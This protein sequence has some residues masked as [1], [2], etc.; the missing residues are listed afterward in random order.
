MVRKPIKK[1]Q[2]VVSIGGGLGNQLFQFTAGLVAAGQDQL[3]LELGLGLPNRDRSMS[4]EILQYT[5]PSTVTILDR[6]PR[7]RFTM[8]SINFAMIWGKS[9]RRNPKHPFSILI[10]FASSVV[11]SVYFKSIRVLRAAEGVGYHKTDFKGRYTFL[12]G[13]F[14]TYFWASQE[15][16]YSK[17]KNLRLRAED[18]AIG[19]YKRLA[20]NEKPLIVH[21]RL[22]DYKGIESFG[23]PSQKYYEKAISELW[24]SGD[25]GKI[26]IFT[27]EQAEAVHYLPEWVIKNC[28]WIPEIGGSAAQTLEVMRHGVGYVIANSTYSWWGAFL[29]YTAN[30]KVIAPTPWFKG[31]PSPLDIIPPSWETVEAWRL[32][33]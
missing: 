2:T 21:V 19:E 11:I 20:V 13:Y 27:N 26:W 28:R 5:L 10:N 12:V 32:S 23:I 31:E 30:P 7:T 1:N 29:S 9:A 4:P 14:Q 3:V 16:T 24:G 6:Q 18:L 22:G 8:R 17:L 33:D 25:Y 15:P